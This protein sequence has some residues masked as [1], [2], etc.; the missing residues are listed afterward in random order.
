MIRSCIRT[1][2]KGIEPTY[3][4]NPERQ[5]GPI[6]GVCSHPGRFQRGSVIL[7]GFKG[8]VVA[9]QVDRKDISGRETSIDRVKRS[10][11]KIP[12]VLGD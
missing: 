2:L 7:D 3:C 5:K 1:A 9:F 8:Q 11:F 12:S 4:R 10:R 6:P